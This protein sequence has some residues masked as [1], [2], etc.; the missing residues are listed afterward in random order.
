MLFKLPQ[1]TLVKEIQVGFNNFWNTEH[2]VYAE[3]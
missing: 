2:E 1:V 3:P